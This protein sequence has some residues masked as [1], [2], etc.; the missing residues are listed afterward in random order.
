M[1]LNPHTY[2]VFV[3]QL[4]L[5][6]LFTLEKGSYEILWNVRQQ[7]LI[8]LKYQIIIAC[9]TS[10]GKGGSRTTIEKV[11]FSSEKQMYPF[12]RSAVID[13]LHRQTSL[14]TWT[15]DFPTK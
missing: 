1:I 12:W 3:I 10:E 5:L 8:F 6:K 11:I 7:P 9:K 15:Y 13:G 14:R 4:K 2:I